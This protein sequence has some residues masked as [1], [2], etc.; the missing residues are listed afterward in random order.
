MKHLIGGGYKMNLIRNDTVMM[1]HMSPDESLQWGTIYGQFA[2]IRIFKKDEFINLGDDFRFYMQEQSFGSAAL[3]KYSDFRAGMT[4]D[5]IEIDYEQTDLMFASYLDDIG[6]LLVVGT[7]FAEVEYYDWRFDVFDGNYKFLGLVTLSDSI[8][9]KYQA[10][11]VQFLARVLT[12]WFMAPDGKPWPVMWMLPEGYRSDIQAVE[13]KT[14]SEL[15]NSFP[16]GSSITVG[17]CIARYNILE[18]KYKPIMG[19]MV[20]PEHFKLGSGDLVAF[21]KCNIQYVNKTFAANRIAPMLLDA[22]VNIIAMYQPKYTIF[23]GIATALRTNGSNSGMLLT[24][25]SKI[26]EGNE[27]LVATHGS[28]NENANSN[29]P[30][31]Q[32]ARASDV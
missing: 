30:L 23:S 2:Y 32:A 3:A 18:M 26:A 12:S 28:N 9:Y 16:T 14:L 29:N 7:F 17:D 24:T 22:W 27:S 6:N 13:S 5:D 25:D 4:V 20:E 8:P 11:Y 10:Q 15:W 31:L 1:E 19:S 21:N